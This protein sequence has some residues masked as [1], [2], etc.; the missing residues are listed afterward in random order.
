M[1]SKSMNKAMIILYKEQQ[2]RSKLPI[3]SRTYINEIKLVRKLL[4][5]LYKKLSITKPRAG[6]YPVQLTEMQWQEISE[7]WHQE[8]E[9][10]LSDENFRNL[11]NQIKTLKGEK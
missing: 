4:R 3:R 6:K 2:R 5:K 10:Q 8:M 11:E 1:I 7:A 9:G